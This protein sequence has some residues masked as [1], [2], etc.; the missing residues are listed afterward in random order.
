ML[1]LLVA[2]QPSEQ[3]NVLWA[4]KF[5]GI[6]LSVSTTLQKFSLKINMLSDAKAKHCQFCNTRASL[7]LVLTL[8][9]LTHAP[10]HSYGF[11][12]C[13][14]CTRTFQYMLT[15]M[16]EWDFLSVLRTCWMSQNTQLM[17][18]IVILCALC[19]SIRKV[20]SKLEPW[21]S[22]TEPC[23]FLWKRVFFGHVRF[24]FLYESCGCQE[25]SWFW[26]SFWSIYFESVQYW[27]SHICKWYLPFAVW[28]V[29]SYEASDDVFHN[30]GHV[31]CGLYF[32]CLVIF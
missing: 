28:Q 8:N 27:H 12:A 4:P 20:K 18:E 6:C 2:S 7:V 14:Y 19:R 31:S 11:S 23:K 24:V 22:R 21:W 10:R 26:L 1:F 13:H 9:K 16:L 25:Y 3:G 5:G 30:S 29:P 15:T 17:I 32:V